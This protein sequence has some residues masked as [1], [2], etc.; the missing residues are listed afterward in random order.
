L[1]PTPINLGTR[2]R[3]I[4]GFSYGVCIVAHEGNA[5]GNPQIIDGENTLLAGDGPGDMNGPGSA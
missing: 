5:L 4:E 3:I 1:A 2:T